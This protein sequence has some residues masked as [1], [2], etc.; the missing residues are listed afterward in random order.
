MYK[1]DSSRLHEWQREEVDWER[2]DVPFDLSF[3]QMV[4]PHTV[5]PNGFC[6]SANIEENSKLAEKEFN[7]KFPKLPKRLPLTPN[8][9]VAASSEINKKNTLFKECKFHSKR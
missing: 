2:E 7:R 8:N 9:K 4:S 1:K 3:I 6:F 5:S